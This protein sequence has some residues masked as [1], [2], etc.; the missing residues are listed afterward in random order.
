MADFTK[1]DRFDRVLEEKWGYKKANERVGGA[2]YIQE[3]MVYKIDDNKV[4]KMNVKRVDLDVYNTGIPRM[5]FY[6]SDSVCPYGS[7]H[8][9]SPVYEPEL[10]L[11][12]KKLKKIERIYRFRMLKERF[13]Q[14]F[15]RN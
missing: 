8:C 6:R 2:C 15:R 4:V 11:F 7:K 12:F 13:L 10:K 9:T 1:K 3:G 5:V 14:F